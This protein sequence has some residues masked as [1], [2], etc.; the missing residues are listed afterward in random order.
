MT[1]IR[2]RGGVAFLLVLCIT[3]LSALVVAGSAFASAAEGTSTTSA[4]PTVSSDK[5]DYAPGELVT[6]HGSNWTAGES[7]HI[8]VN[9]TLGQTWVRNVDVTADSNGEITDSFNLPNYFISDYDV[10]ATG[11]SG[12]V[13]TT[14]T[15]G[16]AS[17]VSGTVTDSVT[18]LP[19]SGA[20]VTCTT[21]GGCN[22]TFSTTSN[23]SGNYVF[24]GANKL[25]FAGNEAT[26]LTLTVSRTGYADGTITL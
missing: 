26:T 20:T 6:L 11:I 16:N 10:T 2:T 7:V 12:T 1:G 19:I 15:D 14:F 9:D 25:T 24:D 21:S 4:A 17:S 8:N 13:R 23:A 22:G 18:N 5:A 3:A